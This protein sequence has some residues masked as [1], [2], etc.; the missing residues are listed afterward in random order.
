MK[1]Y[2]ALALVGATFSANANIDLDDAL[3]ETT[4][5]LDTRAFYMK[6]KDSKNANN[7]FNAFTVGG[8]AKAETGEFYGAKL[9]GAYYGSFRALTSSNDA[10]SGGGLAT[11]Q[12]DGSNINFF[13]E[14]YYKQKFAKDSS[15]TL[16]RQ[17]LSTPLANDH[18]LR[19]LPTSYQ[20]AVVDIKET[21]GNQIQLGYIAS[22]TQLGSRNNGFDD[23][24]HASRSDKGIGYIYINNDQV[25]YT[26]IKMQ[27][28]WSLNDKGVGQVKDYFYLDMTHEAPE[29]IWLKAQLGF[30]RYAGDSDS[31]MLGLQIE[32]KY[33]SF[34]FGTAFNYIKANDYQAIEAGPLYTDWQQGYSQRNPLF[35]YGAYF[36]YKDIENVSFKYGLV[37]ADGRGSNIDDDFIESNVDL[38]M[39]FSEKAKFRLRYSDKFLTS[40]A[41]GGKRTRNDFR[42]VFYLSF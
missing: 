30:N 12:N 6:R 8:I 20:A 11:L 7:D 25:E 33:S 24:L 28:A 37:K 39:H 5:T 16:G 22:Y 2:L 32:K 9:G 27:Y 36:V 31:K 42:A 35:A 23:D 41:N 4:F 38:W 34:D 21:E 18:D 13:G 14:L 3:A 17:R 19:L 15:F 40:S 10:K 29:D 26:N 1:K